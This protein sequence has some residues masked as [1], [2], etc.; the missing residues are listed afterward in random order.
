M[1]RRYS[2][3]HERQSDILGTRVLSGANYAADGVRN[4][5]MTLDDLY[6]DKAPPRWLSTHPPSS[7]RVE[8]LEDLIETAGYNRYA[9]EGVTKHAQIQNRVKQLVKDDSESS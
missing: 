3:Q 9:Y 6:G 5:M 7:D 1:S 8:Y 4:L 2:R